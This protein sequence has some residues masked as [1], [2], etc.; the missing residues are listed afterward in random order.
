MPGLAVTHTD[1]APKGRGFTVIELLVVITVISLLIA[2]LLPAIQAAREAA[3]RAQCVNNLKQ[4]GLAAMNYESAN[5]VLPS[6]MLP[7]VS[8]QAPVLT[9]GLSTFVRILP[10]LDASPLYNSANFSR[11]AITPAN[12]TVAST[13]LAGLWCPSDPYVSAGNLEDFNYG[14]PVGT[15]IMQH[16]TSYGGCQGTWS[17][18]ILPQNPYFAAQMANMNGTIFSCSS[19]RLADISDGTG[20]TILFAET[21][22]GRMPNASDL[23]S[24]RWWNVGVVADSMISAYYP[25]N[26]ALKGV[27]Y[28][29]GNYD[30]WLSTVGSFHPGGANV[31]FCDG[32]VR[33]VKDSI[34]SLPYDP[35][36]GT[37]PAFLRDS[38][39]GTY[40][41]APGTQLG[42]WQKLATRSFNEIVAAD[43]L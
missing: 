4:L 5:T 15:G 10:F 39:S 31:G 3:R 14:A 43:S 34:Q 22:Y 13:G 33:F 16:H 8:D 29:S 18:E 19:V 36:S 41:I 24:A 40:S 1:S 42:V 27:P 6:G 7:A 25:L 12:G 28:L 20:T 32:S 2:L 26:G 21:S 35:S 37:I 17:I 23:A 38:T 9:W 30:N 11:Q